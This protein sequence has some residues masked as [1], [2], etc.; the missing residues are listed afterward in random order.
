MNSFGV[1]LRKPS[2]LGPL[3]PVD[4]DDE[5]VVELTQVL[6]RLDDAADLMVRIGEVGGVDVHLLDEQPLLHR[7]ER[8]PLGQFLRPG[9]ELG[10]RRHDAQSLLV[11]ED[12]L[13]QLVPAP[14]EELHVADLLDPLRR[15]MM[16]R[17]RTAGDVIDEEGLLGRDGLDIPFMYWMASSAMAVVRFQPGLPSNG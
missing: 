13:A 9:R 8:V 6:D 5:G 4:V 15:R 7:T 10:V 14:V 2:E 17:V 1:P 16:R 3:S 12:R 11:G